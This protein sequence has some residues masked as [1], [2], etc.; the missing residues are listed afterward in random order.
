M[1]I[2]LSGKPGSGKSTVAKQLA[3]QLNYKRYYV[4]GMRRQA[5]KVKGMTLAEFNKLGEESDVTDKEFDDFVKELSQKEDDFVVEGRLA[6]HF[7]PHSLK[8]FL[9]V[10]EEVGARRIWLA[11]KNGQQMARNEGRNLDSYEDVLDVV[12]ERMKSDVVRYQKYY[13]INVFEP[14]HYDLF[15]DT[16][17]LS[18]QQEFEKVYDFIKEKLAKH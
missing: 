15:L 12:R 17:N 3:E 11:L 16:T 5:A 18:P 13:Q 6:F 9:D 7:I 8:I 4:G 10:D 1:I 14:Q 2:S